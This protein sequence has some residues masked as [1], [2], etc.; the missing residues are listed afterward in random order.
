MS[1]EN[2][3]SLCPECKKPIKEGWEVCPHCCTVLPDLTD[4]EEEPEIVECDSEISTNGDNATLAVKI[5]VNLKKLREAVAFC[6][7]INRNVDRRK[8]KELFLEL[9]E[10]NDPLG[11]M[12]VAWC[13]RNGSCFFP[14]DV[15]KT[16]EIAWD[17]IEQV[18]QL[19]S[20]GIRD[21][22]LPLGS[23]YENGLGLDQ[24]YNLA[25]EWYIKAAEANDSVAMY[26]LGRMDINALG[27]DFEY[28]VQ[29]KEWFRESANVGN[30]YGTAGLALVYDN[31]YMWSRS[32]HEKAK[33]LF[34]KAAEK[35]NPFAMYYLGWLYETGKDVAKDYE[36]ATEWY[37]KAAEKGE[38]KAIFNLGVMYMKGLGIVQDY[39]K[40][41]EYYHRAA[42]FGE[43]K[44][45]YALGRL[46]RDGLGVLQDYKESMCWFLKGL[47]TKENCW[48]MLGIGSLYEE[49][50][51]VPKDYQKAIEWYHKSI[52]K[53]NGAAMCKLGK[54]YEK[55]R[56]VIKNYKTAEEWY[57]KA[58]SDK[59]E[60]GHS[61]GMFA[62]GT[63][64]ENGV[65]EKYKKYDWALDWYRKA[66]DLGNSEAM[67]KLGLMYEKGLGT[68]KNYTAAADW[69][70]K[71]AD[72][73]QSDAIFNLG[74]MYRR[75]R[76]V[77]K[78]FE[79]ALE[80]YHIAAQRG[81]KRAQQQFTPSKATTALNFIKTK[82]TV[83]KKHTD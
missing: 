71:A 51:G 37:H 21:A 9:A 39:K 57:E 15:G 3:T 11:K 56:G 1:K 74:L 5:D 12:W 77:T 13:Y 54:M 30:S 67:Y 68:E 83:L 36:K 53:G 44:A 66:A 25:R 32:D 81:N 18:K 75:G 79:K 78:D 80:L 82:I 73:G 4:Q 65:G 24:D 41:S 55:G 17:V 29:A 47:K 59:T 2:S 48:C 62:L 69:Y 60:V 14:M 31:D 34:H 19:A 23:A 35:E 58:A 50:G 40:A 61:L 33:M 76:G 45:I 72:D 46:Y 52:D 63:Y 49:G 20:N 7:G 42:D 70:R 28:S 26:S 22:I 16:E 64:Y 43:T 38:K 27:L 8:A 6:Y 10:Q